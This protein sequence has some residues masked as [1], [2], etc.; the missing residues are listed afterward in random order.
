AP[1]VIE[2]VS[3]DS[4][5]LRLAW[6][7]ERLDFTNTPLSEVI[8]EF[9]RRNHTQF[10]IGDEPTKAIPISGMLNPQNIDDF[11]DMLEVTGVRT[12]REDVSKIV[13]SRSAE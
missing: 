9:N 7:N 5:D 1:P 11:I 3:L 13:L 8:L 10:V 2:E 6:K 12:K 4:M